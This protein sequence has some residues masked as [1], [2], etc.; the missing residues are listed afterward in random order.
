MHETKRVL[1][2]E[3]GSLGEKVYKEDEDDAMET[4]WKLYIAWKWRDGLLIF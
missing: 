4:L 2:M 3:K 1:C